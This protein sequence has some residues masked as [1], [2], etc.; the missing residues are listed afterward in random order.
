MRQRVGGFVLIAIAVVAGVV[1]L[2][3][4]SYVPP[5]AS[6]SIWLSRA[7][8]FPQ[9]TPGRTAGPLETALCNRVH[10]ADYFARQRCIADYASPAVT[11]GI[12]AGLFFGAVTALALIGLGLVI[13]AKRE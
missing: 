12:P 13:F 9:T 7:L 6:A 10:P 2:G 5:S 3:N 11:T 1:G 4:A 8:I